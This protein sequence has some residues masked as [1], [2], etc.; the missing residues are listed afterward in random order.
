VI[1][2]THNGGDRELRMFEI[3]GNFV[4]RPGSA[5]AIW[6]G[7]IRTPALRI[8]AFACAAR[9]VSEELASMV[10]RVYEGP[11]QERAPVYAAPEAQLLQEP[12]EGW[13][14]FDFWSDVSASLELERNAFIW[15]VL[16]KRQTRA[17][18]WYPLDPAFFRVRREKGTNRKIVEAWIEGKRTDVTNQVI[19][20]RG[21]SPNAGAEGLAVGEQHAATL[22]TAAAYED[23]RGRWFENDGAPSLVLE[24]PGAPDK[25]QRR[26]ILEAWTKRHQ[27]QPNRV[28][29]AWNGMKVTPIQKASL[30]EAQASEV[31]D[32][33]ARDDARIQRIYPSELLHVSIAGTRPPQSAELWTD[34][35]WR[36][37]LLPRVRRIER[38]IAVDRTVFPDPARYPRFDPT[39][40]VRGDITTTANLVHMLVQVGVL[41]KNE[42]RAMFGLAPVEGGDI[43][44]ETPVGAKQGAI[45]GDAEPDPTDPNEPLETDEPRGRADLPAPYRMNGH[46]RLVPA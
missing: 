1:L 9:L 17:L 36:F 40:F 18:E 10:M 25:T 6:G 8:A 29:L 5:E 23:Y 27:R 35:F 15:K 46:G 42:G 28:G 19:H 4:P 26:E 45:G 34:L 22:R 16:D 41:T 20:L 13:S 38:A 21:W 14:S 24:V 2:A 39:E 7:S 37:S 30:Q 12:A 43:L 3:V 11:A 44:L 32:Q 31:A 33:I